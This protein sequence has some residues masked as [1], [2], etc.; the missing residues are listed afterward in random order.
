MSGRKVI[1]VLLCLFLVSSLVFAG[2]GK[3]SGSSTPG[4]GKKTVTFWFYM[5][6]LLQQEALKKVIESFNNSQSEIV[7]VPRYVPFADF[8]KQLSIGATASELP[9]VVI[10]DNPDSASYAAMGIFADI[11][12]KIDVSQYYD[13][14]L[15]SCKL[16]NKLYGVPFGSNCLALYYNKDMLT[17]AN[18]KV[19]TTWD[20]LRDA[21][22]KLTTPRVKGFAFSALQNEEGTFGFLTWVW[23]TGTTSYQINN[24]QGIKALTFISDLVKDGSMPREAM[25]WTQGDTLH[26]FMPGNIAM[27]LN[28]PWQIPTL[29]KDAPNLNWDVALIPRDAV[30]VSGLG[31]EN[32]HIINNN[33]VAASL[34]F[35]KY[36]TSP[37]VL[38]T[39]I[40]EFGYI[41]A[42]KD[43][44]TTQFQGDP[45]MTKFAEQVQ[46]ALPRGPHPRWPEISD[47]ISLA[48]NEVMAQT[49]T[50]AQAAAKAQAT[51]DRIVR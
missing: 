29:R 30:N 45:I 31:G 10:M 22:K 19:P 5:E 40:N 43:V 26:Q 33:N 6:N 46:Y 36:M 20:E 37:A 50:P 1:L 49:S 42:R 27:M 47:A 39:Y 21:A 32:W 17:A 25:N 34:E 24:A 2:G 41:A 13:G 44:A 28:G 8:K 4:S 9:D 14:H 38:R 12:G 11:T 7:A 15:G 18:V 23:S 48:F 3:Q 51:I 16:N 35:I